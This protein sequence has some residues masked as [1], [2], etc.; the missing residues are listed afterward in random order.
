[1]G[2]SSV[3]CA[4]SVKNY[5]EGHNQGETR[6]TFGEELINAT[7]LIITGSEVQY[8]LE[9]VENSVSKDLNQINKIEKVTGDKAIMGSIIG[10]VIGLGIG[11]PIMLSTKKV[12]EEQNG[13][14]IIETTTY[15]TWPLYLTTLVGSLT[16]QL[17]GSK[18]KTWETIY[19]KS[20]GLASIRLSPEIWNLQTDNSVSENFGF[21][22]KVNIG[23]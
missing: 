14:L 18:R 6:I 20:D 23:F 9:G 22:M 2:T 8:F 7:D 17:I 12:E 10:G 19:E 5:E 13:N 4:Q 16:G 15:Q 21:G 11:V 1:M 3:L